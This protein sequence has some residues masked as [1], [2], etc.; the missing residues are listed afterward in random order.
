MAAENPS[1]DTK[2]LTALENRVKALEG[3]LMAE[4]RKTAELQTLMDAHQS[5]LDQALDSYEKAFSQAAKSYE[6]I[7]Q[8]ALTLS[9]SR[10]PA[11]TDGLPTEPM[12]DDRSFMDNLSSIFDDLPKTLAG[13]ALIISLLTGGTSI[14]SLVQSTLA[15]TE[16]GAVFNRVLIVEEDTKAAKTQATDATLASTEAKKDAEAANQTATEAK[17]N[18]ALAKDQAAEATIKAESA[19]Q[20]VEQLQQDLDRAVERATNP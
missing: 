8:R 2:R 5:G 9:R 17:V 18:A 20:N 19:T 7:I 4:K 11:K 10:P 13:I 14:L 12:P 6:P 1:D 3:A 16:V 15:K